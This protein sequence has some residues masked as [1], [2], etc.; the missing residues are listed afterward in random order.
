MGRPKR[1]VVAEAKKYL[2]DFSIFQ[3]NDL[4]FYGVE[5]KRH[6]RWVRDLLKVMHAD[7][8][9]L[10]DGAA[11]ERLMLSEMSDTVGAIDGLVQ[12]V[13]GRGTS[14]KEFKAAYDLQQTTCAQHTIPLGVPG[15]F[16]ACAS[17]LS[18]QHGACAVS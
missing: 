8:D 4:K 1:D 5:H 15:S 17:G 6:T 3:Q 12:V 11:D 2:S 14:V 16:V 10:G 13:A 18:V 9:K 7:I